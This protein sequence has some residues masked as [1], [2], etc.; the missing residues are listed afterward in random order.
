MAIKTVTFED[1]KNLNTNLDIARINKVT[2]E[3]INELKDVE[4]TNANNVWDLTTLNTT[5][6]TSLVNAINE[7]NNSVPVITTTSATSSILASNQSANLKVP[8]PVGKTVSDIIGMQI[9]AVSSKD[10]NWFVCN[11]ANNVDKNNNT[12]TAY[13]YFVHSGYGNSA[14][15][16][17]LSWK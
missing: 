5:D 11:L 10:A 7:V 12:I 3:D 13:I 2:D 14:A 1:K 15:T 16:V 17:T 8:V 6:K 9:N 4:N